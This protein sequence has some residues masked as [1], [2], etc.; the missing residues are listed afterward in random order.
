MLIRET[1]ETIRIV[2]KAIGTL[3]FTLTFVLLSTGTLP[4]LFPMV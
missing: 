4:P 3:E 2:D 1:R